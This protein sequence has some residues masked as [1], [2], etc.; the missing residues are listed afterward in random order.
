MA[1]LE[2]L[3]L[4]IS[5]NAQEATKGLGKLISSLIALSNSLTA[6]VEKLTKLN[7]ELLKLKG[8]SKSTF[9]AVTASAQKTKSIKK[10]TDAIEEQTEAVKKL[11][12]EGGNRNVKNHPQWAIDA[13]ACYLKY[14]LIYK[15]YSIYFACAQKK[16]AFQMLRSFIFGLV[17]IYRSFF[18]RMIC[19]LRSTSSKPNLR[20]IEMPGLSIAISSYKTETLFLFASSQSI[21]RPND[22]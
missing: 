1:N 15:M 6:P 2:T 22:P 18:R 11:N 3:E 8:L 4:R 12:A 20:K 17:L 7:E 10:T 16:R 19:S 5:A 9:N 21:C 14:I 13:Q